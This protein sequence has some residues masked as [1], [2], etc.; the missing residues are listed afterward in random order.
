[1]N[2]NFTL[3][4]YSLAGTYIK[5]FASSLIMNEPRFTS[6]VSGG[7]GEL[8]IE[9]ALPFDDFDEGA[10]IKAMNIVKLYETDD[11]NNT[12]PI[13]IYSGYISKYAPFTDE[14]REGVKLT[15]LGL[16]S[17]LSLDYFMSG[18]SFTVAAS[19]DPGNIAKAIIDHFQTVYPSWLI[20]Y[21]SNVVNSGVTVTNNF[22]DQKW[23]DALRKTHDLSP[24]GRFWTI[25]ENGEL[26]FKERATVT[27]HRFTINADV[28]LVE[29]E[30]NSEQI[31]N[32]YQLRWGTPT[33]TVANYS[34]AT[35]ISAYGR[36]TLI[37]TASDVTNSTT[38]DERGNKKI[39][40]YKDPRVQAKL[41]IN[42]KYNIES[43]HPGD[44]C[45]VFNYR[46]GS[47]V[48]PTL[49]LITSVSYTPDFIEI[50]IENERGSF[51]QALAEAVTAL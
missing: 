26:Y 47:E 18:S 20:T 30:K 12:D 23:L 5:T 46:D 40:D 21:G 32:Y 9:L 39:D 49:M 22:V 31:I 4:V 17:L 38:A 2:K 7:Q 24:A 10:S 1:M 42:S 14:G 3:K 51:A 41:R 50:E 25:R 15:V 6:R 36:H 37:E 34:D 29:V 48:F 35:S 19:N 43:V 28:S 8:S 16:V 11:E 44:V 13:L 45:S 27:D 33:P